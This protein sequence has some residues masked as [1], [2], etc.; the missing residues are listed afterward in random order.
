MTQTASPTTGRK[1]GPTPRRD[2]ARRARFGKRSGDSD[3]AGS[4]SVKNQ[5]SVEL[6]GP[7]PRAGLVRW[8]SGWLGA[9]LAAVVHMGVISRVQDS[10]PLPLVYLAYVVP[11][12]ITLPMRRQALRRFWRFAV[13]FLLIEVT[14]QGGS[15]L[16]VFLIAQ[17][18]VLHQSWVVE[19]DPAD[20]H[21]PWRGLLRALRHPRAALRSRRQLAGRMGNV[22]S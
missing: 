10:L 11:A 3:R 6:P 16:L 5:S 2:D 12:A 9:Y 19:S 1:S 21:I 4:T 18:W 22:K 17:A 7:E 14:N 15:S 20:R 8:L 13:P